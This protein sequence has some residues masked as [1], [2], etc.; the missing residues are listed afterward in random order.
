MNKMVQM[1]SEISNFWNPAIVNDNIKDFS[2]FKGYGRW[3]DEKLWDKLGLENLARFEIL[4][5]LSDTD[6]IESMLEWG[7]GGGANAVKFSRVIDE[8]YGVDISSVSISECEM[9]IKTEPKDTFKYWL[10]RIHID[11]PEIVYDLVPKVDFFLCTSVFQ[12]FPNPAYGERIAG[13]AYNMLKD[14][15]LAL[16]QIKYGEHQNYP[17]Y[18]KEVAKF[19]LYPITVFRDLMIQIGFKFLS[20]A[21]DTPTCYAYYYLEK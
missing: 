15:G 19:T 10:A 20:V 5:I 2:H 18:A 11:N 7:V 16:I 1:L 6:K 12:H 3:K 21:L 4:K 9:R 13:I 17:S 14:K 8:F